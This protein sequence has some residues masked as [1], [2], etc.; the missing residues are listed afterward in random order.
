MEYN[1]HFVLSIIKNIENV[2]HRPLTDPEENLCIKCIKSVPPNFYNQHSQNTIIKTITSAVISEIEL[3]RP[4]PHQIQNL[5]IHEILK[6]NMN[7]A[8]DPIIEK[9]TVEV[10]IE[11]MFGVRDISSLV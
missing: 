3:A 1:Q 2:I 6:R 9:K 4:Q 7:I 10:S 11:S 5:D 8:T